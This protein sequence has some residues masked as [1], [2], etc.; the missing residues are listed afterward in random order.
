MTEPQFRIP[1]WDWTPFLKMQQQ[2]IEIITDLQKSS[3]ENIQTLML[4]QLEAANAATDMTRSMFDRLNEKENPK[5]KQSKES[6]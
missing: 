4:K 3:F 1:T 6:A 2:N 5:A